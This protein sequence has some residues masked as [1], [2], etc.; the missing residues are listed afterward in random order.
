MSVAA[1][2]VESGPRSSHSVVT[3]RCTNCG[4]HRDV[5]RRQSL[6]AAPLCS[7]CRF[8]RTVPPVTDDDRRWWLERFADDE[9]AMIASMIFRRYVEPQVIQCRR[10]E[11]LAASANGDA[12]LACRHV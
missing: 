4:G 2:V 9:L 3:V 8:P 1:L 11:L 10:K 7:D 5:S 6:R 12:W